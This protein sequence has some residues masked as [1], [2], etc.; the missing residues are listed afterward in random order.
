MYFVILSCLSRPNFFFFAVDSYFSVLHWIFHTV[1]ADV[2]KKTPSGWDG[3]GRWTGTYIYFAWGV[4]WLGCNIV[5]IVD[6]EAET[7]S[8]FAFFF[9]TF[10]VCLFVCTFDAHMKSESV[11]EWDYILWYIL[12]YRAFSSNLKCIIPWGTYV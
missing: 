10:R 5:V 12:S 7:W 4:V 2:L 6:V 3:D 8:F 11:Q 1:N 9:C